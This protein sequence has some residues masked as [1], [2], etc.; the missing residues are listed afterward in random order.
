MVG[1]VGA[2]GRWQTLE[3]DLEGTALGDRAGSGYQG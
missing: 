3:T 1:A 2:A